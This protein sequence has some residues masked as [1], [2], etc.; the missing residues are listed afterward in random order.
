M[1][2]AFDLVRKFGSDIE[3]ANAESGQRTSIMG[4]ERRRVSKGTSS[5]AIE[6]RSAQQIFRESG[7]S[8]PYFR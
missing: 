4:Q 1:W 2:E 6:R 8:A 5:A 3:T 7:E